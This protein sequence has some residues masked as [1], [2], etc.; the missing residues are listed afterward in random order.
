M[1]SPKGAGFLYVQRQHQA[2]IE[3]LVVS[4]GWSAKP[5]DSL[6]SAFLDNYAWHGT[7]D[8]SAYLS[9]PAAIEFQQKY[10]WDKVREE[11]HQL[12]RCGL[13]RLRNLT[14]LEPAYTSDEF[15]HQL[16]I[17]PLPN[18]AD[19]TSLKNRLYDEFLVEVPLTEYKEKQF[20][21]I[22]V[23]GYN[24]SED[25]DRLVKALNVILD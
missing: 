17:A 8:F 2:M 3:P 23:Q 15:Y 14:G 10:D 9:V 12:L 25:I 4:W 22:S 21:R 6:G 18:A 7:Q 16:A 13:E 24:S 19:L 1:C 20:V 11:C 5:Q